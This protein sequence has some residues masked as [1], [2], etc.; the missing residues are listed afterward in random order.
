M[1]HFHPFSDLDGYGLGTMLDT[2]DGHVLWGHL[3]RSPG[4]HTE[5]WHLP[6]E[7]LTLAVAWNDDLIDHDSAF[8]RVLLRAALA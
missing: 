7:N 6:R 3:G 2:L 4:T 8:A 1:T 5:L